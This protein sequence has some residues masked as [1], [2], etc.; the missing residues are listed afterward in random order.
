MPPADWQRAGS[1]LPPVYRE[2]RTKGHAAEFPGISI[3][4]R[5]GTLQEPQDSV[6]LL[7]GRHTRQTYG[8]A[9]QFW[10]SG[11]KEDKYMDWQGDFGIQ[12]LRKTNEWA[13]NVTLAFGM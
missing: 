9:R 2:A 13:I 4:A 5:W 3:L 12:S 7:T 8:P 6:F 1:P 10:H 11:F